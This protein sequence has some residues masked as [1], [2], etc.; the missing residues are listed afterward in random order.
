MA[1]TFPANPVT[2]QTYTFSNKTWKY[3]G[4]AW[5]KLSQS[6]TTDY[7]IF[8]SANNKISS[9]ITGAE[10]PLVNPYLIS[11]IISSNSTLSSADN[12][13]LLAIDTSSAPISITLPSAPVANDYVEFIDPKGTWAVN[14]VT[15][16]GS[17]I[18]GS[19]GNSVS[20]DI[21]SVKVAFVY[22]NSTIGWCIV[23]SNG[24]NTADIILNSP[25]FTGTPTVNNKPI[26][27][28]EA[29]SSSYMVNG[30]KISKMA[31]PSTFSYDVYGK[32]SSYT[33]EGETYTLTYDMFGNLVSITNGVETNTM[34][35]NQATGL[36]T[37][38][39]LTAN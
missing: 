26:L 30:L 29:S 14:K 18:Y 7:V 2:D 4:L 38:V 34:V 1:L 21:S 17:I 24:V 22:V 9:S 8:D 3:N 25:N 39:T 15:I 10:I 27:T 16:S 6:S 32:V 23:N 5:L 36:L 28:Y 12:R 33:T 20:L 35:Y 11:R 19:L 13:K 37:E 31:S